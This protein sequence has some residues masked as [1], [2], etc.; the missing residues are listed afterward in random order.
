MAD[1]REIEQTQ[2][3]AGKVEEAEGEAGNLAQKAI[4]RTTP[5]KVRSVHD[6]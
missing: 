1:F 2:N 6:R 3:E 5:G 4:L